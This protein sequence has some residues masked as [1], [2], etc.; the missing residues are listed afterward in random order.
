MT[1]TSDF[2]RVKTA[3]KSD[4]DRAKEI[5]GSHSVAFVKGEISRVFDGRG[6]SPLISIIDSGEDFNGF[7]VA[8]LIIGKAAAMLMTILGVT[9][10]YGEVMSTAGY[11]YLTS[12]GITAEYGTLTE[13]IV[14]RVGTGRCPMETAVENI[15]DPHDG[16]IAMKKRLAELKK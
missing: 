7:S 9:A 1:N 5:R 6:V 13:M 15:S 12:R 4:L 14:N 2:D 16:L 8:D 3:N 11:E 10:V